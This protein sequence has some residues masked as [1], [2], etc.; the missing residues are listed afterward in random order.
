MDNTHSTL[1]SKIASD[2]QHYEHV[3]V[4]Q[5]A[6]NRRHSLPDSTLETPRRGSMASI[7]KSFEATNVQMVLPVSGHLEMN[8]DVLASNNNIDDIGAGWFVWL[9]AATASIAGSLFGYDTGTTLRDSDI[10]TAANSIQASYRQS[11]CTWERIWTAA[12]LL[13]TRKSSSHL[14]APAAHSLEQSSRA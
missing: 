7:K 4:T 11:S 1:E 2:A 10:E 3:P 8:D 12:F 9:V 6:F 5:T 14:S 13:R